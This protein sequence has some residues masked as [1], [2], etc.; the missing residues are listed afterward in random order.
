[1]PAPVAPQDGN[2]FVES[3]YQIDLVC[4]S[5]GALQSPGRCGAKDALLNLFPV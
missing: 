4:T 1:L 2:P 3:G 5:R